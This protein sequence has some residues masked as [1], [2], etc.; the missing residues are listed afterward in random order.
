MSCRGFSEEV[1]LT[2]PSVWEGDSQYLASPKSKTL[3]GEAVM[4]IFFTKEKDDAP[5]NKGNDIKEEGEMERERESE[6]ERET[7]RK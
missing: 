4:R 5:L 2:T 3:G 1:S 6:R 7:E